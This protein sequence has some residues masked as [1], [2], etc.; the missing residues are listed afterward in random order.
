MQ[1][2]TQ[3]GHGLLRRSM[4]GVY[5]EACWIQC[6]RSEVHRIF[7][8]VPL[9]ARF[10]LEPAEVV[11][12]WLVVENVGLQFALVTPP[13]EDSNDR[14]P[15]ELLRRTIRKRATS[16]RCKAF[17]FSKAH[18]QDL[19]MVSTR[20]VENASSMLT[21]SKPLVET[22]SKS[23]LWTLQ[24]GEFLFLLHVH[25]IELLPESLFGS[26]PSIFVTL[27]RC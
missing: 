14:L 1:G 4:Q 5:S 10:S 2:C 9:P 25:L 16:C 6:V 19:L 11:V 20:G 27:E 18:N 7:G 15:A 22:I 24:A 21:I 17:C 13:L 3:S 26:D 8:A 12:L 23:L